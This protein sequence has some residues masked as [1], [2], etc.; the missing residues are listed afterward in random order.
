MPVIH[1]PKARDPKTGIMTACA[2]AACV[3]VLIGFGLITA[4]NTVYAAWPPSAFLY[5]ALGR[6]IRPPAEALAIEQ[7]KVLIEN[8]ESGEIVKISGVILNK[9]A[10][11]VSIPLIEAKILDEMGK[12]VDTFMIKSPQDTAEGWQSITFQAERA[13]P[14]VGA[15]DLNLRFVLGD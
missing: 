7:V 3:F 11:T 8:G 13:V 14:V 4:R 15:R 12:Y 5:Q 2:A 6:D 9:S 1:E 10:E